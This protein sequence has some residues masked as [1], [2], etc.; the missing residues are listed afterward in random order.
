VSHFPPL[1]DVLTHRAYFGIDTATNVQRAVCRALD[2]L[3]L[4]ALWDD[5]NVRRAF[6]GAQP[7]AAMPR[8]LVLL[9][10][11]RGGKSNISAACAIRASQIVDVSR[12][13]PGEIPR[14]PLLAT[15][16]DAATIVLAHLQGH[17][18][19]RPELKKLLFENA[20]G[21]QKKDSVTSD[22]VYLRHPSGRPIEIKTTALSRSGSTLVGRWLAGCVFDEAPRMQGEEDGVINLDHARQAILGRML[23]GA[24]ILYI[25]S[26][27]APLGPVYEM[28]QEHFGKPSDSIVVI[29]ARGPDMNPYYWTEERQRDLER[30][31]PAT[32]RTDVL[33]EFADHEQAM[34][35]SRAVDAAMRAEPLELEPAPGVEYVAA[36]DPA[37]RG[38]AWTLIVVG[39]Y[40]RGGPGG[41]RPLYRVALARQWVGSSKQPLRAHAVIA[42]IAGICAGFKIDTV[43]TDRYAFDALRDQAEDRGLT[44]VENRFTPEQFVEAVNRVAD[45]LSEGCL[46]LPPD[47]V[48]RADLVGTTKRAT[49]SGVTVR[50]PRTGDGRHGDYVPSLAMCLSIPP[51]PPAADQ[52]PRDAE[53]DAVISRLAN[54]QS[55]GGLAQRL[56]R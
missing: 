8:E 47:H 31:K 44:L 54:G 33:A 2:G 56:T 48:L 15:D 50:L 42:E 28:V 43:R 49:S 14:I 24:Q 23:P 10:G 18:L 12:L 9:A 34:F 52:A 21:A 16:K 40:G 38:N 37:T 6:G 55:W 26:P 39:C 30:R 7:P 36:M 20:P 45:E 25:G 35:D 53:L 13:G 29:R 1:E 11:I 41:Q 17:L 22:T 3:P 27:W 19:G 4:G 51:D 46:E 5:D 32:Y